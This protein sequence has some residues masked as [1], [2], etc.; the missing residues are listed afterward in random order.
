ML[1]YML[2]RHTNCK[3]TGLT[4][5]NSLNLYIVDFKVSTECMQYKH[6]VHGN[7]AIKPKSPPGGM[8]SIEGGMYGCCYCFRGAS[9]VSAK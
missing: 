2:A 4:G 1:Y 9:L 3:S 5:S 7:Y 6:F 8:H